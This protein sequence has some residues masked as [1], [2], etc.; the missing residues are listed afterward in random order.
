VV[1]LKKHIEPGSLRDIGSR[2]AG[3]APCYLPIA[4][5]SREAIL[6]AMHCKGFTIG[7]FLADNAFVVRE[8]ES[9]YYLFVRPNYGGYRCVAK[10]RFGS[11]SSSHD[12]DH[13]LAKNLAIRFGYSYVLVALVSSRINRLH[14]FYEK[15]YRP[16]ETIEDM[17]EVCFADA[18]IFDKALGRNS[19]IRRPS[20][21]LRQ[22]YDPQGRI[23]FGLTLKQRGIW[24]LTFGFDR[25]VPE[26]F[27][28]GLKPLSTSE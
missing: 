4:G 17:P 15:Y 11:L 19:K 9:I 25:P 26:K 24:N 22:G 28:H 20:I 8:N 13:M 16:P 3:L 27:I 6:S 2:P 21:N 1:N 5:R 14:G 7:K 23:D 12:V 18:R 10:R